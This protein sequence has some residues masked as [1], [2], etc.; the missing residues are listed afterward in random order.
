M[1][2]IQFFKVFYL[3]GVETAL[4]SDVLK[5][6]VANLLGGSFLKNF[7]AVKEGAA[8]SMTDSILKRYQF[9]ETGILESAASNAANVKDE[10]TSAYK[11]AVKTHMA[12][13]AYTLDPESVSPEM[14]A[15]AQELGNKFGKNSVGAQLNDLQRQFEAGGEVA[16]NQTYKQIAGTA[17][18]DV[19]HVRNFKLATG[20]PETIKQL[21]LN[22]LVTNSF[23]RLKR[24]RQCSFDSR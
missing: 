6:K 4:S 23:K 1:G 12:S 3:K 2:Q 22:D 24:N 7:P 18:S 10:L 5:S 9:P 15:T 11:E 13:D 16:G 19:Q 14:Q 21:A 8:K 20:E 17:L